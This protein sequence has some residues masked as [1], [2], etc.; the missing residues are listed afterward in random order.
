[1]SNSRIAPTVIQKQ[2]TESRRGMNWTPLKMR[3]WAEMIQCIQL[4]SFVYH[5]LRN[6]L[7]DGK[8]L[9]VLSCRTWS[10]CNIRWLDTII[11]SLTSV[12]GF[13]PQPFTS[14]LK[15]MVGKY[16]TYFFMLSRRFYEISAFVSIQL[17]RWFTGIQEVWT[18]PHT[19][20]EW[21]FQEII[22][23]VNANH[24]IFLIR[25][26]LCISTKSGDIAA[27]A[28][29]FLVLYWNAGQFTVLKGGVDIKGANDRRSL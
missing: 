1:M 12:Q 6:K 15:T 4:L 10:E 11:V 25:Q 14:P 3:P 16:T 18:G 17:Y 7:I 23:D 19:K 20:P 2:R 9:I 21:E 5:P 28:V 24:D 8:S 29:V 22:R 27:I 26:S 13:I